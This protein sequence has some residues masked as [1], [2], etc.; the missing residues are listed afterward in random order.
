MRGVYDIRVENARVQFKLTLSRNLTIIRGDSATGKTTLIELVAEHEAEGDDSGV[1]ISSPKP[2][3]VLA[4]RSWKAVLSTISDSFVFIDEGNDFVKSNEF[5]QAVRE[6]DNYYV[7]ATREKLPNLPY[8]VEEIYRLVN[9]TSRYPG[10]RKVYSQTRRMYGDVLTMTDP[11]TVIVE[12]SN[13]GYEFFRALCAKSGIECV[14]A[15]GKA[16]VYGELRQC[17]S[18]RIAVIADGAAFGP[19][20][21]LVYELAVSR[22]AGLFLPESFEWLVLRSGLVKDGEVAQILADPASFIESRDYFSWERFFTALLVERTSGTYLRYSKRSL[23]P[24]YL[25]EKESAAIATLLGDV[26]LA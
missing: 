4:G 10:M 7:I 2:C 26:D 25:G 22:H 24:A 13:S 9:T 6:S 1:T 21:E 15:R 8:S 18:D 16:H 3:V 14:S 12:D 20:M 11:H 17:R 19:E 5:A 23:N